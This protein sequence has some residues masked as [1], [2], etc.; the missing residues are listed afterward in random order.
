MILVTVERA[1][2]LLRVIV[3][4]GS[5]SISQ[6]AEVSATSSSSAY[7][8]L[9]A[10]SNAGLIERD[11]N[12]GRFRP[13]PD[14]LRMAAHILASADI[15]RMAME[16]MVE[17]VEQWQETVTLCLRTSRDQVLY[18]DRVPSPRW[19]QYV[20][21]L[22]EAA[23]LHVGSSGRA[24]LAYMRPDEIDQVLSQK[25]ESFTASTP[26]DPAAIK[27]ELALVHRRG[28]ALSYGERV[29]GAVG[30]SAPVFDARDRVIGALLLSIPLSHMEEIGDVDVV[31][32]SVRQVADQVSL[33]LGW[34]APEVES[35]QKTASFGSP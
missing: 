3:F 32:K 1:L 20:V 14:L 31:G 29:D 8:L 22:G 35:H 13:G 4:E 27:E 21:P 25:L 12:T 26:T 17:L 9:R 2:R 24:I 7:R 34:L 11:P 15:R 6:A 19:L 33:K 30:V 23:Q 10:L 16:S 5:L 18:F 28:Y